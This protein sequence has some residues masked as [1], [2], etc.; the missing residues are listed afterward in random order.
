MSLCCIHNSL[1]H[2]QFFA[3]TTIICCDKICRSHNS[4]LLESQDSISQFSKLFS[5]QRH[6]LNSSSSLWF[7]RK[8]FFKFFFLK[9]SKLKRI[10]KDF[11]VRFF[12]MLLLLLL[13]FFSQLFDL[14]FCS[15][16]FVDFGNEDPDGAIVWRWYWTLKK[17]WS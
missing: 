5:S 14:C 13:F 6:S 8:S 12:M 11:I 16:D 10:I 15:F 4:R 3:A 1:L 7:S 9:L 2:S 17:S